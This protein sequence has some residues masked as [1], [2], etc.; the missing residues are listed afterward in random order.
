MKRF[1]KSPRVNAVYIS[2]FTAFY[3]L[4]FF[5][6]SKNIEL[7]NALYY[8]EEKSFWSAWSG[9]IAAGYHRYIACILVAVTIF[10][11]IL[12]I[13]HRK[14]YDEYHTSILIHCLVAAVALT[15]AAIAIF[16]I[17][18]LNE[19]VGIIEK[20]TL[21]IVIHWTT[22]VFANLIYVLLCSWR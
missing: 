8:K 6:S 19:P 4:I 17:M 20:F 9:F 15:L 12:L 11:V 5:L 16:Y 7:K 22:V 2:I 3:T 21:F 14:P 1:L 13:T 10:I 18:I